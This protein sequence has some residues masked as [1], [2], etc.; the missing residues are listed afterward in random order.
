MKKHAFVMLSLAALASMAAPACVVTTTNRDVGSVAADGTVYLG[1][2]LIG[3]EKDPSANDQ[4]TYD[5]GAQ[6]GTFSSIRLRAE[7]PVVIAQVLVIFADGE[8]WNAPA[9]AELGT[10]QWS[11]PI[12]FPGP[13]AIHS[14]V[15]S[16]RPTTSLLSRLEIHGNR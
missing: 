14:I 6:L 7:K 9:P 10:D 13:R 8:R 1:W 16:G 15:V 2:N 5:V 12:Q 3:R 4:D 11:A